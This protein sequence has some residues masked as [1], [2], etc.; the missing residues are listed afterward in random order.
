MKEMRVMLRA[1]IPGL[2]S[3]LG[4]KVGERVK[5]GDLLLTVEAMKMETVLRAERDGLIKEIYVTIGQTIQ[6][7]DLLVE[8]A[9]D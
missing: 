5:L 4:V 6:A 9:A 8:F 1:P 2:V 3:S 7:K